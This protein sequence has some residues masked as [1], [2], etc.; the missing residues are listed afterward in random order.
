MMLS[1]HLTVIA[2]ASTTRHSTKRGESATHYR[3]PAMAAV[4]IV[5]GNSAASQVAS[6]DHIF[7]KIQDV[8]PDCIV[9]DDIE[10]FL[11][12]FDGKIR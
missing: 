11:E 2:K 10:P 12:I 4:V 5:A 9:S 8:L 3:R 1:G 6:H 7:S